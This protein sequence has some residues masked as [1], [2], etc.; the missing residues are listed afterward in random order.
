MQMMMT[1]TIVPAMG[2]LPAQTTPSIASPPPIASTKS[3]VY[4]ILLKLLLHVML[5]YVFVHW[6]K[7]KSQLERNS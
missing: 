3:V 1:T 5:C 2:T 6:A 4:T 7:W